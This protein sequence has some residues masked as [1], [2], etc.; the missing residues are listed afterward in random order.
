VARTCERRVARD[1]RENASEGPSPAQVTD[2]RLLQ[3][4]PEAAVSRAVERF[5]EQRVSRGPAQY[6]EGC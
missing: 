4:A 2:L 3:P 5:A 1:R 6:S